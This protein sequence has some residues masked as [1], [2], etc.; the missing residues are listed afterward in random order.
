MSVR[1]TN[2]FYDINERYGKNEPIP[3]RTQPRVFIS[4]QK[5][6]SEMANVVAEYLLN[7]GID[8]YLLAELN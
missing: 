7:A 2:Y 1:G 8:I 5:K 4:H 3:V 6:D